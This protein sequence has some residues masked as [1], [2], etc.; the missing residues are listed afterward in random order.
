MREASAKSC[1]QLSWRV[2][3]GWATFTSTYVRQHELSLVHFEQAMI[4]ES[5]QHK[6]WHVQI[7]METSTQANKW[8]DQPRHIFIKKETQSNNKRH[9][10]VDI[11]HRL[12]HQMWHVHIGQAWTGLIGHGLCKSFKSHRA[13]NSHVS[14]GVHTLARRRRTWSTRM[15]RHLHIVQLS[16]QWTTH[17]DH[18]LCT[19]FI[20]LH[21]WTSELFL[22]LQTMVK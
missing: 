16:Q 8:Q 4:D 2:Y 9:W 6:L 18:G 10:P 22:A 15:D 3:I 17:I 7:V 12:S 11:G 21:V 13:C 14:L 5:R 1:T 19:S 20:H